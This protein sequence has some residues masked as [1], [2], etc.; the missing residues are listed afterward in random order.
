MQASPLTV[1][2]QTLGTRQHLEGRGSFSAKVAA[3]PGP[4]LP[5]PMP[6][7]P[8]EASVPVIS[9]SN[10]Q[11]SVGAEKPR[12]NKRPGWG[13][14]EVPDSGES[15]SQELFGRISRSTGQLP[16]RIQS[17]AGLLWKPQRK[18]LPRVGWGRGLQPGRP[19]VLCSVPLTVPL[20]RGESSS[21][22]T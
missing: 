7:L 18:Q 2:H 5:S 11:I 14:P 17:P 15:C 10:F 21:S 1:G 6:W 3:F 20:F 12:L 16:K 9:Q 4:E 19:P 8:Q 22:G 13:H